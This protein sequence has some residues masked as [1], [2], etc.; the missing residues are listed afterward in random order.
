MRE[1]HCQVSA[2]W[3]G[4]RFRIVICVWLACL[5]LAALLPFGGMAKAESA[6][7]SVAQ[8]APV[9]VI[10]VHQT[11][12]T[13]LYSFMQRAFREAEEMSAMLI[14][15]D[16]N[17]L[18]GEV[19]AAE[20]IGQLISNSSI[21]TVAYV[22]GR[23]VSAGSYI[24]LNAGRIAM[25]P[26][27]T[28][29]AAA[30]VDIAGAEVENPKV[31]AHWTS[32]MRG[33]AELRGRNPLIAEG[34]V[35]KNIVVDMPEIGR[36]VQKGEIVSLTAQ[37]ALKVGYAETVAETL[38]QVID[39]A[40]A[41]GHP[42]VSLE[43]SAAE[44]LA[45]FLTQPWV[46][47]LLLIIGLAGVAIEL[48]V[49]GF[50]VP[51]ILGLLGFGLYFFGHFISGLAGMEAIALFVGG[52]L[53]LVLEI[54]VPSFG[55]LGILGT[56]GLIGG[57]VMAAQDTGRAALSL[58]VASLIA[59]VTVMIFVKI[60]KR[61]GVWNRF[62]LRERLTSE[63]GF[64]SFKPRSELVGRTGKALTPLRPSGMALLGDE[65][66]DVVT[67]GEFIA[68]GRPVEVIQVEGARIVVREL[69]QDSKEG[70]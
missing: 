47:T 25:E 65:R 32:E 45:R 10:P 67:A 66:I 38:D 35:D 34:M 28:M 26:G 60:F 70:M 52:V 15:L 51:G 4:S 21:P 50:G 11:I 2:S 13:G 17:T 24:A 22:H 40:G 41:S 53:L 16:I 8:S 20:N 44:K 48:F 68:A 42:V 12:N 69:H 55:I 64:N 54:F 18:G 14:V 46:A 27:S 36:T 49:P 3:Q 9:V 30:V 1:R 56:L 39:F 61:R 19:E 57:V 37:E 31:L 43:P 5:L 59:L 29:G 62:I 63:E 6:P 7:A 58:T 23:A 33:A